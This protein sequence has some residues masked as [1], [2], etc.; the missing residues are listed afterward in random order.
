MSPIASIGLAEGVI[1]TGVSGLSC[2]A[3]LV[4]A[5]ALFLIM[6]NCRRKAPV[7]H[8]MSTRVQGTFAIQ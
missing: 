7:E 5:V 4:G 8:E 6:V 3:R 1:L 2:S